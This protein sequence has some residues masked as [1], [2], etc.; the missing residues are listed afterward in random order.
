MTLEDIEGYAH[1]AAHAALHP[2]DAG[3]SAGQAIRSSAHEH[4]RAVGKEIGAAAR[5]EAMGGAVVLGLG[6]V[7]TLLI[8]MGLAKS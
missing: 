1:T 3:F 5:D 7:A 4:A 8:V 6:A 2:Y